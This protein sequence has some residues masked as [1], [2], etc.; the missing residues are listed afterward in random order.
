MHFCWVYR[1]RVVL[2]KSY[3]F[4]LQS[5]FLTFKKYKISREKKTTC[6][7]F[8]LPKVAKYILIFPVRKTETYKS[9]IINVSLKQLYYFM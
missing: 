9:R 3:F 4:L 7:P 2:L 1:L 5:N 6:R 8:P